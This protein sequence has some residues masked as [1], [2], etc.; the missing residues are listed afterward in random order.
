MHCDFRVSNLLLS[1]SLLGWEGGG[2]GGEGQ[3]LFHSMPG[4]GA[5]PVACTPLKGVFAG[6][7]AVR[8]VQCA[9]RLLL[10]C[11]QHTPLLCWCCWRRALC[12]WK[13]SPGL[14][15]DPRVEPLVGGMAAVGAA[16]QH[17]AEQQCAEQH[18][19]QPP[20]DCRS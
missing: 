9:A 13:H 10:S 1:R 8:G 3:I 11:A 12:F 4:P 19:P 7:G 6:A 14:P 15:C 17:C 5:A 2:E 18:P 20:E 16:E